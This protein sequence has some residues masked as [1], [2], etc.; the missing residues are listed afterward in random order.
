MQTL[1]NAPGVLGAAM[2]TYVTA[3]DIGLLLGCKRSKAYK[4]LEEV[5]TTAVDLGKHK[6]THGKASKY[7]FSEL[8]GIPLEVIDAV[9]N[10]NKGCKGV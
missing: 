6:Y 10:M 1:E 8:Y 2:T 5:N 3:A 7:L 9:I 4:T